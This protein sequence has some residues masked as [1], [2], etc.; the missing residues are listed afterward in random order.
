MLDVLTV[1]THVNRVNYVLIVSI[2]VNCVNYI[3]TYFMCLLLKLLSVHLSSGQTHKCLQLFPIKL[4]LG[5]EGKRFLATHISL[6]PVHHKYIQLI[7]QITHHSFQLS[8][9]PHQLCQNLILLL[10][11]LFWLWT[12]HN[13]QHNKIVQ[14]MHILC[15]GNFCPTNIN[16]M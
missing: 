8:L 1:S 4:R 11:L 6:S 3:S 16:K 12:Q 5:G 7:A 9:F 10:L 14:C 15:D 13:V 2:Y